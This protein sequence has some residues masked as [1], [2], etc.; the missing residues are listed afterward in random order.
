MIVTIVWWVCML[1]LIAMIARSVLSFVSIVPG[2]PLES[3][4]HLV[5]SVTDPVLRPVRRVLP[6]ARFGGMGL[7]LSPLVVAIVVIILM[8]F[9]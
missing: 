2:S 5:T 1:F 4:N 8:S 6:P 9:L 3:L 7:D